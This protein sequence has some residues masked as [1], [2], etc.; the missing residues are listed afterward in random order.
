M[1]RHIV[2]ASHRIYKQNAC[3]RPPSEAYPPAPNFPVF[4][5]QLYPTFHHRFSTP[6]PNPP[7]SVINRCYSSALRALRAVRLRQT[8]FVTDYKHFGC[9]K[10]HIVYLVWEKNLLTYRYSPHTTP[11]IFSVWEPHICYHP[12]YITIFF[13]TFG[14]RDNSGNISSST[15][16][17]EY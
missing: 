5:L 3:P 15:Y 12:L 7:I 13:H 9:L 6:F 11:L 4:F 16:Y 2:F 8:L 1:Q 14:A 10:S 17:D